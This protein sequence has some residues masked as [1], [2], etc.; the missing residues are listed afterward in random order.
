[1]SQQYMSPLR[2]AMQS[3]QTLSCML[4]SL[5]RDGLFAAGRLDVSNFVRKQ[6][7]S[8]IIALPV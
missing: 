1:M 6:P 4:H 3:D 5:R 2:V 8:A 7:T